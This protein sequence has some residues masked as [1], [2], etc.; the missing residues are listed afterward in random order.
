MRIPRTVRHRE[1]DVMKRQRGVGLV[2]VL[3]TF[4]VLSIG[5][6]GLASMQRAT[7]KEN[8]DTAQRSQSMWL[9]QE[10][11]ERM[12]ANPDGLASGYT[13]AAGVVNGDCSAP[14]KFCSNHHYDGASKVAAATDCSADEMAASDVWEVYCGYQNADVTSNSVDSL[15]LTGVAISC[16]PVTAGVCDDDANFTVA[17]SWTARSVE[18][19]VGAGQTT[20]ASEKTISLTVRP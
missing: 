18:S 20:E 6:L 5:L 19:Q 1:M 7:V 10:L 16:L 3:V 2:E 8:F 14:A 12:R 17:M 15:Q 9:V 11:I 4:L 13:V